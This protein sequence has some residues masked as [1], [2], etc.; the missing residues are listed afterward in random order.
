M[1]SKII[2]LNGKNKIEG[3]PHSIFNLVL[4]VNN[5]E[6]LD[7]ME[8]EIEQVGRKRAKQKGKAWGVCESCEQETVLV[9]EVGL[10]GPCCWGEAETYN[11][12]W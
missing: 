2:K 10:C 9:P 8:K 5:G 1:K 12:N 6:N 3:N 4:R 7:D 11:G